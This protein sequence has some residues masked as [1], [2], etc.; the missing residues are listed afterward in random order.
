MLGVQRAREEPPL[1]SA[2][3]GP[4]E[5]LRPV[6]VLGV[7]H[8]QRLQR[9]TERRLLPRD[10]HEVNVVRHQA[11]GLDR[12]PMLAGIVGE[13]LEEPQAVSLGEEDIF[14]AV[15]ALRDMMRT[16]PDDN[17]SHARH[18]SQTI[19]R[20][21]PRQHKNMA[22]VPRFLGN[23]PRF[24]RFSGELVDWLIGSLA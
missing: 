3:G 4:A 8:V 16:A 24:S 18:N 11:V 15:A 12:Q 21:L 1:P 22:N 9:R 6:D 14:A 7:P 10:S 13:Q 23:V 19:A 5:V 17:A 2:E 20:Q